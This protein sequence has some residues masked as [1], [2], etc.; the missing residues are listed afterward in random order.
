MKVAFVTGVSSGIGKETAVTLKKAGYIVYG[1]ARNIDDLNDLKELGI[2]LHYLDL[3]DENSINEIVDFIL[4]GHSH[5]DILVNNAGYGLFGPVEY[6]DMEKIRNQFEVNFFGLVSLTKKLLPHMRKNRYGKIV[7][8]SSMGGRLWTPMGA[9]YHASKYA[10]EGF[11][12]CLRLELKD[13]NID[14]ILVEPGAIKSN[15]STIAANNLH[16]IGYDTPYQKQCDII[17]QSMKRKYNSR[18]L[19]KPSVIAS[20]ILKAIETKKPKTRYLLGY[21][22]KP[23]VYMHALFGDKAY[24]Q[25][26]RIIYK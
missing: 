23:L 20:T 2:I 8:I 12:H 26:I 3:T 25:L 21:G 13:F 24:D 4:K 9:I 18:L 22:A 5:I 16:E 7:N 11:S 17:S 15:W 1:G 6:T 19:T 10:L 14:V